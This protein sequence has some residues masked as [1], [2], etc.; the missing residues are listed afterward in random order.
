MAGE[1][2]GFIPLFNPMPVG[3]SSWWSSLVKRKLFTLW[4]GVGGGS[5]EKGTQD[6]ASTRY[7]FKDTP[8]VT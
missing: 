4:E 7:S 6:K 2:S 3:R 1:S 8:P 5:R